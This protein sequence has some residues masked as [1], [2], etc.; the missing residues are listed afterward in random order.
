MREQMKNE[1]LALMRTHASVNA[2]R[3]ANDVNLTCSG[4]P[5]LQLSGT[6]V[7]THMHV[8]ACAGEE[9]TVKGTERC[10]RLCWPVRWQQGRGGIH[11]ASYVKAAHNHK[12]GCSVHSSLQGMLSTSSV[13]QL[14]ALP[15]FAVNA[16]FTS[17][18]CGIVLTSC[19]RAAMKHFLF[20]VFIMEAGRRHAA[21]F[22][23]H[24]LTHACAGR[25]P[26]R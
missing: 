3:S 20:I 18:T 2:V 1:G 6:A 13:C 11:R 8:C 12:F 17:I 21:M 23:R 26:R 16:L 19:W 10:W 9:R 24:L 4:S 25:L 15:C 22:F 7:Q 14:A 5:L